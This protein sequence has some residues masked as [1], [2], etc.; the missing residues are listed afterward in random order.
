MNSPIGV[1]CTF[2]AL[3]MVRVRRIQVNGQW[4]AVAQGRQWVDGNGRH[5]LIL[6]PQS[7]VQEILLRPTTLIWELVPTTPPRY[8]A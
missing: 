3:G 7:P 2:D 5:I 6:L 8:M 4:Q 1:E